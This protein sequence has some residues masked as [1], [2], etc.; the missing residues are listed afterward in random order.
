MSLQLRVADNFTIMH[1]LRMTHAS[2]NA[3]NVVEL[4]RRWGRRSVSWFTFDHLHFHLFWTIAIDY[5]GEKNADDNKYDTCIDGFLGRIA[6]HKMRHIDTDVA[7]NVSANVNIWESVVIIFW[8]HPF[9]QNEVWRVSSTSWISFP[10][11]YRQYQST[12]IT[13]S[14]K[15]TLASVNNKT[16]INYTESRDGRRP[17]KRLNCNLTCEPGVIADLAGR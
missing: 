13:F 4:W 5:A 15:K 3:E 17:C 7:R 10:L 8:L 11:L 2:R 6:W 16:N 9:V 14:W 1:H 12:E